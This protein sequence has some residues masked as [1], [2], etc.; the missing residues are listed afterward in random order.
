MVEDSD[1]DS[2]ESEEVVA[3]KK[4]TK[5][6]TSKPGKKVVKTVVEEEEED[7][8][9]DESEEV[10][11][12]KKVVKTVTKKTTKQ[13]VE[14]EDEEEEEEDEKPVHKNKGGNAAHAKPAHAGGN[15]GETFEVIAKGLAFQAGENDI[16]QHFSECGNLDSVNILKNYDGTSKGI[17]FIRFTTEASR[18]AA[19]EY[20]GSELFGRSI[21]VE[22]TIPRDQ[23]PAKDAGGAGGQGAAWSQKP[24][25]EQDPNSTTVFVGNLSYGSTEDSIR[26]HFTGC[27]EIAGVRVAMD[28]DGR[29]IF[30]RATVL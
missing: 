14:E 18:D 21:H 8:D 20:E 25:S 23:R 2:D 7:D 17:A 24:R 4:V 16:M 28:Q 3:T 19:V 5:T 6:V 9:S 30:N 12:T 26:H 27:G 13:P 1:D 11:T 29:V 15:T 10:V 22:K